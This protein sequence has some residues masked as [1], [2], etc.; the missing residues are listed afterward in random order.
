MML[1]SVL[2]EILEEYTVVLSDVLR[3]LFYSAPFPHRVRFL[4]LHNLPFADRPT[5]LAA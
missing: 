3:Q 2:A 5:A 1:V 4:I